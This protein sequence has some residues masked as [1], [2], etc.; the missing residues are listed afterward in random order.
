M[1][2]GTFVPGMFGGNPL[3]CWDMA[4]N[5]YLGSVQFIEDR[6]EYSLADGKAKGSGDLGHRKQC[7]YC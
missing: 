7:Y 1:V 2:C 3:L 6:A 5:P 4:L